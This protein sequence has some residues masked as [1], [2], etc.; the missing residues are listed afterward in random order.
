MLKF[1]NIKHIKNNYYKIYNDEFIYVG[2]YVNKYI[3]GY[4]KYYDDI[5]SYHGN[6]ENNKFY[7]KGYLLYNN[8]N[9]HNIMKY[10]GNFK[11]GLKHGLGKEYYQKNFHYEGEFKKDVKYG[12][13]ILYKDNN[14]IFEGDWYDNEPIN[15]DKFYKMYDGSETFEYNNISI[16]SNINITFNNQIITYYKDQEYLKYQGKVLNNVYNGFGK[17]FMKYEDKYWLLYE[18]NFLNGLYHGKG[19]LYNYD[20]SIYYSGF[21]KQGLIA[22]ENVEINFLD[23]KDNKDNRKYKGIINL[24]EGDI[25]NTDNTKIINFYPIIYFLKGEHVDYIKKTITIGEWTNNE[26]YG[27][28]IIQNLE[29]GKTLFKGNMKNN[30]YED[31]IEYYD[32]GNIKFEG[33][34]NNVNNYI[35]NYIYDGKYYNKDN[36]EYKEGKII[37]MDNTSDMYINYKLNGF[38]TIYIKYNNWQLHKKGNFK[39]NNLH[40]KGEVY[41][42]TN[43]IQ[44]KGNYV[45]GLLE[46]QGVEYHNNQIISYQGNYFNSFRHGTGTLLDTNGQFI[47]NGNFRYGQFIDTS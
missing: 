14:I 6:W 8:K 26:L 31:G 25:I 15:N 39:Y 35:G 38:G 5:I 28:I 10:I 7:G 29:N 17:Y 40:G 42:N 30:I 23:Y 34:Y 4:G 1:D 44:F 12:K 43:T 9:D 32:N 21:F 33:K 36:T 45:N 46:G 11:N 2:E 27:K 19:I 18:G 24:K 13:G 47:L 37:K 41:N 3:T 22:E 20:K 16:N